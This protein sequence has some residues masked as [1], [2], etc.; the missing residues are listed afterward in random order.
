MTS[1]LNSYG[2]FES[3]MLFESLGVIQMF[4]SLFKQ[5]LVQHIELVNI[6]SKQLSHNLP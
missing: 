3:L 1:L 6:D 5:Q 4:E 2:S